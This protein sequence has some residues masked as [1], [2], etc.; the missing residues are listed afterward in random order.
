MMGGGVRAPFPS[1][2]LRVNFKVRVS[3]CF[4]CPQLMVSL[5]FILSLPKGTR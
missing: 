3:G 1:T 4:F 2:T 5:E